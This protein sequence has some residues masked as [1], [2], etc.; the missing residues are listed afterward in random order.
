M[1]V[2]VVWKYSYCLEESGGEKSLGED[3]K[4]F[5]PPTLI[6]LSCILLCS[7]DLPPQLFH[8]ILFFIGDNVNIG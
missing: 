8:F 4:L 5:F 6:S 2:K 1:L 3:R 7:V